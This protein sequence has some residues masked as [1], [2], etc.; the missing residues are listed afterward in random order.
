LDDGSSEREE[1]AERI[2]D[3]PRFLGTQVPDSTA[4]SRRVDGAGLFHEDAGR[5]TRDVDLGA[6]PGRA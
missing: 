4:E 5:R 1:G 3:A 2:V 6:P